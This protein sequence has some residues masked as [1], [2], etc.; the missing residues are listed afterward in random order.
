MTAKIAEI[1]IMEGIAVLMLW[2]AHAI[3]VQRKMHLIAGYNERTAPRV[4]DKPGLA[5]L[6]GRVCLLVGLASALMPLAT[7]LWGGTLKGW[8][9]CVGHY[10]GFILGVIA[11]TMLQSREYVRRRREQPET[12]E[13]PER[14]RG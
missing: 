11:L 13:R 3:G 2:F 4:T 8:A 10:G 6:I 1:L 7:T 14:K 9:L 5:R 12:D